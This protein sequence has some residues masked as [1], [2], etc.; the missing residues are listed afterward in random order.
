VLGRNSISIGNISSLP[1]SISNDK[2]ILAKPEKPEKL[3]IGPTRL[4]PGP[5][6]LRH[7]RTAV[8][9]V[10]ISKLSSATSALEIMMIKQYKTA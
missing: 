5:M 10:S 9:V 2:T 1:K 8:T 4:N 7:E 3:P 6:L